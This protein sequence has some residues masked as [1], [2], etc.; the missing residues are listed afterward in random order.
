MK[1]TDLSWLLMASPDGNTQP[2]RSGSI[3]FSAE[4]PFPLGV[5]IAGFVVLFFFLA[6]FGV[7]LSIAPIGGAVISPGIVRVA[8]YRKTVQHL[9]GGIVDAIL[10]ED[11]DRVTQGQ[12]LIQLSNVHPAAQLAQLEGQYLEAKAVIARLLAEHDGAVEIDFPD[13]LSSR[14]EDLP[15]QAIM[16]GQK[17]IFESRR[18]LL[19]DQRSVLQ[20]KIA[21]GQEEIKGLEGQIKAGNTRRYLLL[22][23]LT[24]VEQLF[25]EKLTPR[26]RVLAVRQGVAELEGKLSEY[27]A[28][29]AKIEQ[30]M[31]E[32]RLE[33]SKMQAAEIAQV[34]EQLR[35]E[36]AKLFD[37]SQSIVAARD[38]LRRTKVTAPI[39]GIVVNLQV[40][41]I[42]GVIAAGQPV[43]DIV[44][45]EEEP[46]IEAF[47]DPADI[48][49]VRAGLP[50]DIQ[51]TSFSR[52]SRIPIKGLVADVS[53]D[54]LSDPQ[55]GKPYYRAR[56]ELASTATKVEKAN[57]VTGMG[58]DV[59]IRTSAR[60]PLD[61]ILTPI[62]DSLQHG[63]RES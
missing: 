18:A 10:V 44:P 43:L 50:A 52:R 17:S 21:Q 39:D 47:I 25:R 19:N 30:G 16:K 29:I 41:T 11:G 45:T 51:L 27:H 49:E 48:D 53:A 35:A 8:S 37:L 26:M 36:G 55:T 42:N 22:D 24:Q 2:V 4:N 33:I 13:E 20:Q 12:L 1:S 9:E 60:T 54:R 32:M 58:A 3:H 59:F 5:V 14:A 31:L 6:I 15:V 61:Y 7:W 23:E 38:V 63:L 34:T 46:I 28:E 57:L 62:V 56:I 40:H